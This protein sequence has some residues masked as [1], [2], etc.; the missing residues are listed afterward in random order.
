MNRTLT[1]PEQVGFRLRDLYAQWGY[2]HYKMSKFEEYDLYARNKD[3]LISDSAIT[4]LDTSGRLMALKPDVTLSIVKNTR[5]DTPALQKLYY[6]ENVYRVEK[7][8]QSF[9][10]IPQVGLECLGDIDD[11][12]ITEVLMLAAESLKSISQDAILAISHLGLLT[13]LLDAAGLPRAL[14]EEALGCIGQKNF[15]ELTTLCRDCGMEE[16][17]IAFLKNTVS[18]S[19]APD[20]VLSALEAAA[21]R[22]ADPGPL[23]QLRRITGALTEAGLSPMVRFDFSA[24]DD[25]RY[26]NGI[27]FKGFLLGVPSPIL[28]GGQYDR[29]MQK[30]H[31]RAGAIGFAVYLNALQQ[32]D[33]ARA[34]FDVDALLLYDPG[35]NPA[36]L[37]AAVRTLTE[38]GLRVSVQPEHPQHLRTRQIFKIQGGEVT[39]LDNHA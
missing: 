1:F 17:A 18:L 10:E 31:R 22:L 6:H 33:T 15:H 29:L 27:V 20:A 30:M 38:Q 12:A 35:T 23:A 26:Y 11:W 25:L 19:G 16:S 13:G 7:N 2:I 5:D 28:S 9:R 36:A 32:L 21:D 24:V 14:R 8:S 3:F 37:Y 34:D 4:F 39:E